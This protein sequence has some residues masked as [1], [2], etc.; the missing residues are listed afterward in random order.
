M[1]KGFHGITDLAKE[2]SHPQTTPR[3]TGGAM[4]R[5]AAPRP[6][7]PPARPQPPQKTSSRSS[8]TSY[9]GALFIIIAILLLYGYSASHY[10]SQK[11]ASP[12]PAHQTQ[13]SA[14]QNNSSQQETKTSVAEPPSPKE[15]PKQQE[16]ST[17]P[18]TEKAPVAPIPKENVRT[19]YDTEKA[20][21]NKNGYCEVTV[22]N[23]RNNMPVYVRLWDMG[24][25][26]P[27]RAFFI[28]QGEQFTAQNLT[29]GTYEVRYIELY[30]N[31]VA[32]Q[33]SKSE[34]FQLE[35][36]ERSYG[37]EYSQISLTLYRVR[38]GNMTTTK[39]SPDQV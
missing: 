4:P 38:N 9:V 34:R 1:R 6:A 37:V 24:R 14:Q 28:R 25:K 22:D 8:G 15:Q 35:Q 12:Q 23:T 27:V 26:E 29:S 3:R 32:P 17:P 11:R 16:Q 13:Q 21:A 33:G 20:I 18:P 10:S 5:A 36:I 7:V 2:I 39:I 19:G 31:D 30:D